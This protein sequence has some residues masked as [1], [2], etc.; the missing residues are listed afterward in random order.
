MEQKNLY[1]LEREDEW[2]ELNRELSSSP[3]SPAEPVP[4]A[5]NDSA[6]ETVVPVSSSESRESDLNPE[7]KVLGKKKPGRKKNSDKIV[8]DDSIR[9]YHLCI[10]SSLL[11]RLRVKA[12]MMQMSAPQ[13]IFSLLE[14]YLKDID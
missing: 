6:V 10:K 4:S 7:K 2:A 5:E 14:D 1:S 3:V 13:L 12:A 11:R 8:S 9:H